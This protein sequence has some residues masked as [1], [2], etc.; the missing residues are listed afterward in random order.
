LF[1]LLSPHNGMLLSKGNV[2]KMLNVLF[3]K[4]LFPYL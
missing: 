4:P 1:F 2:N 3:L